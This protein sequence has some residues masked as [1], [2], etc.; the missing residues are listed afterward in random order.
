LR[1]AA[2]QQRRRRASAPEGSRPTAIQIAA[3]DLRFKQFRQKA[4]VL[5]IFA[6][7]ASGSMALNR[8]D[9][10]KGAMLRLLREAYVRRDKI[11]LVGFRGNR[12][13]ILLPPSRGVERARRAIDALPVGGG[14]PLA[15]GIR[16]ALDLARRARLTGTSQSV[17]VLLTDGQANV[18]GPGPGTTQGVWQELEQVCLAAR[19]G[20]QASVVIDTRQRHISSGQANRIAG[21]LGGKYVY[22]ARPGPDDVHTV[23][24]EMAETARRRLSSSSRGI[25]SGER[26]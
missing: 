7:D 18:G 22:L 11:A 5:L 25:G 16:A 12:A 3:H 14:T 26:E 15:A 6:V 13:E 24:A 1:A 8:V 19:A 4:G 17:L 10:A 23:V 2:P 9:Q 21:L 20:L